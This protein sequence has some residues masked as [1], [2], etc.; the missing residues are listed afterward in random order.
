M[1]SEILR[2]VVEPVDVVFDQAPALEKKPACPDAFHWRGDLYT[3]KTVMQEWVDLR[4]RGR[5]ARNMSTEHAS[6]AETRGS[7]GVGRY[8]FRV[9]TASNQI[10]DLY[11]D[12]TPTPKNNRKGSWYLLAE[13]QP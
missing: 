12:R 11:Y 4:R 10:F 3:I 1:D 8:Y 9:L 5:F 2:F 13:R 7:W 6:R